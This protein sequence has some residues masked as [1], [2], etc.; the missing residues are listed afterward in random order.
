MCTVLYTAAFAYAVYMSTASLNVRTVAI[1]LITALPALMAKEITGYDEAK[2]QDLVDAWSK[3]F[4]GT[5]VM[6]VCTCSTGALPLGEKTEWIL[7]A[8]MI[9][10]A[11]YSC[12]GP[13]VNPAVTVGLWAAGGFGLSKALIFSMILAQVGGG[14]VGWRLLLAGDDGIVLPG[15]VG[16]PSPNLRLPWEYLA[17]CEAL[18][19]WTL[20]GAV[21]AFATTK[22]FA[23]DTPKTYGAKM[24][25]IALT[26]R[27][28]IIA[29]T[30]TGPAINPALATS[31]ALAD[32]GELP[33][34]RSLHYH[35]YWLGG[36]AGAAAMGL[37]WKAISKLNP[38][39]QVAS[40][41]SSDVF[42]IIAG[43][44]LAAFG[45]ALWVAFF[46]VRAVSLEA[47]AKDIEM[48]TALKDRNVLQ[49]VFR[50]KPKIV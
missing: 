7:H 33:T 30:A 15:H 25:L 3:E 39:K 5:C 36:L 13:N 32:S 38:P 48:T 42:K 45:T 18:S 17:L 9:A 16:G 21:F 20:T 2:A 49:K 37:A 24:S 19:C 1:L 31:F 12:G 6:I 27:A 29:H 4:V 11:D 8:C 28:L 10:V 34:F 43:V 26:V 50:R 35:T 44:Y 41:F 47:I 40:T 23:D 46:S 14:I 22:P